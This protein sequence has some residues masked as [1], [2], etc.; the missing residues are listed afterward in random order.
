M[1]DSFGRTIDYLRVSVTDRCNFR[2]VYCMPEEG[3]PIAPKAEILTFEEI[4]RLLQIGAELGVRKVR[5]TG[6]E[7]LVRK[8]I[9]ELVRQVAAIPGIRD[10]SMT[11]NGLLL[12]RCAEELARAGLNRINVS[13]DTLRA[14]RFQA[15]ARRGNLDDVLTGID[16]SLAAGMSPIKLNC[17]A[18]QGVNDDEVVDFARLTL[19]S[20]F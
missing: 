9:V 11:T 16:A 1:I 12:P 13:L 3:A 19:E 6:G 8:D 7:P 14:D 5:L 15:I 2:C 17:V 10:L 4:A 18:M 20:P